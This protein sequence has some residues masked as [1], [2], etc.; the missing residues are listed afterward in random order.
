MSNTPSLE[1]GKYQHYKGQ[2]YEVLSVARHSETEEYFVVY[3]PLYGEKSTWVRPYDMFV[4]TVEVDGKQ[5]KRFQK[6]VD[7]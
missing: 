6:V 7:K 5:V 4:E 2:Y 1:K 3:K